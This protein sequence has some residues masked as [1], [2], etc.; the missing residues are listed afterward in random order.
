MLS[1]SKSN[2][3]AAS[4]PQTKAPEAH[5]SAG[6]TGAGIY[7]KAPPVFC[8]PIVSKEDP[9][10]E[11]SNPIYR[12]YA[13]WVCL[14]YS[15]LLQGKNVSS[16]LSG[17]CAAVE[18]SILWMPQNAP[19]RPVNF[20]LDHRKRPC[21]FTML[22]MRCF[23]FAATG[24]KRGGLPSLRRRTHVLKQPMISGTPSFPLCNDQEI[25]NNYI[26]LYKY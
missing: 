11:T 7:Y 14:P 8:A 16:K 24:C 13:I 3:M 25:V 26:R 1:Q 9:A 17:A 21:E 2:Q 5:F 20:I 12:T 23:I 10:L 15:C 22:T 4:N 6:G 19:T 18:S